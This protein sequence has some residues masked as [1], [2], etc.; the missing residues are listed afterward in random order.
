M[1]GKNLLVCASKHC[2]CFAPRMCK[3]IS[4]FHGNKTFEDKYIMGYFV[5]P[6]GELHKGSVGQ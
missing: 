1:Q 5:H 2:E 4:S 6:P 3:K